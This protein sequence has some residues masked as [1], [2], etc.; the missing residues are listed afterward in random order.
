LQWHFLSTCIGFLFFWHWDFL[1]IYNR[2]FL[3]I[4]YNGI[5][6]SLNWDF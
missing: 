4:N 1:F 6:L 2:I 5:F 3:M